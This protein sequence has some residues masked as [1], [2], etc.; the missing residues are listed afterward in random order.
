MAAFSSTFLPGKYLVEWFPILRYLPSF[1]PGGRFKRDAGESYPLANRMRDVPWEAATAALVSFCGAAFSIR[2]T[3]GSGLARGTWSAINGKRAPRTYFRSRPR[4][5]SRARGALQER[6]CR[7]L[8]RCVPLLCSR[9]V[10]SHEQLSG[11]ADTVRQLPQCSQDCQL[12]VPVPDALYLAKSLRRNGIL[13]RG[14]EARP[15]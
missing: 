14:A 11:G 5:G 6:R 10:L 2:L 13:P 15:G 1:M 8:H 12:I 9:R 7:S 3:S 4:S